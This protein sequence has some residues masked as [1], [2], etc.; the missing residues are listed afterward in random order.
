MLERESS[1]R[2]AAKVVSTDVWEDGGGVPQLLLAALRLQKD[3][4]PADR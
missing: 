4:T 2:A 1:A 3:S